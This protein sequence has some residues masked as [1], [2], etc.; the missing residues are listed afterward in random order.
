MRAVVYAGASIAGR[1]PRA[2]FS[3]LLAICT[4]SSL[5]VQQILDLRGAI[6]AFGVSRQANQSPPEVVQ[7]EIG[8]SLGVGRHA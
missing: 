6:N 8:V 2:L 3:V 1:D 4:P 5:D 7:Q